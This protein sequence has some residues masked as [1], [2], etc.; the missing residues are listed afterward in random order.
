[1]ILIS[2]EDDDYIVE[3][4]TITPADIPLISELV[5]NAF[6]D[7]TGAVG[8]N[9]DTF[10]IMFGSPYAEPDLFVRAIYKPTNQLVGFTGGLLRSIQYQGKVYKFGV[11]TWA[12]VTCPAS[13]KGFRRAN[14][15]KIMGNSRREAL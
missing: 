15:I 4:F 13:T 6:R 7:P 5:K 9:E 3:Q 10:N 14:G 2:T 11:G 8:F 12:S 1:M